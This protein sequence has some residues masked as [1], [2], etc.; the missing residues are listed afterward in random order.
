MQFPIYYPVQ[1]FL[2]GTC[3]DDAIKNFVKLN[4]AVGLNSIIASDNERRWKINLKKYRSDIRN[5]VGFDVYPYT[6][7]SLPASLMPI[8]TFRYWNPYS[9]IL[10]NG[11]PYNIGLPY[12][13]LGIVEY[14]MDGGATAVKKLEM[15]SDYIVNDMIPFLKKQKSIQYIIP[16]LNAAGT[17]VGDNIT[18]TIISTEQKTIIE[19][20][21]IGDM[22]MGTYVY[23]DD[24]KDI[25]K[26]LTDLVTDI[27]KKN[28][29]YEKEAH[30]RQEERER[31]EEEEKA[32]DDEDDDE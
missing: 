8:N 13:P 24:S 1:T 22:Y 25:N 4:Y 6:S 19:L 5:R 15:Y 9:E 18:I 20:K 7:G 32:E 11:I 16:Q 27:N 10:Y 31:Q 12:M 26:I 28:P 3:F 29:K 17:P 2:Y 23:N 21:K 14:E 30:E